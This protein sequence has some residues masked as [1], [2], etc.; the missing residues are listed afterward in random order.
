VLVAATLLVVAGIALQLNRR[1]LDAALDQRLVA[2]VDSFRNG[3]ARTVAGGP[4]ELAAVARDWLSGSAFPQS[5]AVAIA[6]ADGRVLTAAG[7]LDVARIEGWD[8]LLGATE[9]RWWDLQGPGGSIRALT[10]PLTLD[11]VHQGTIV[12][13]ASREADRATVSALLS[14]IAWA[15]GLGLVF[16]TLLGVLAVRRTLRPLRRM[17]EEAEQIE[18]SGDLSRRVR[19]DGPRDEVG[20]LA[21]AFDGMLARLED[22]FSSQRRFLSDASHELRTPLQVAR[23]QL[24]F[25]EET[26]RDAEGRRSV[27]LATEELERMRRIVE[28]LLLLAR[29]DEGM[30]LARQPVEVELVAREALL[31]GMQLERR[32][33]TVEIPEGLTALADQERLLQVLTNL[34][35]NAIHHGGERASIRIEGRGFDGRVAISVADTGPGIP[36]E[37]L[38]RVFERLYRGSDA[39]TGSPGGAGL[40]LAIA[41]SLTRTMGGE[42]AVDS[43]V[44]E[45]TTFTVT[46]PG[47]DGADTEPIPVA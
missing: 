32:D 46:L 45:G 25:L 38:P 27:A 26:V 14:G 43:V 42:I 12:V 15:S 17:S 33:H 41:A 5:E 10:T 16:A 13:A 24:E 3:P 31:R 35:T 6:T 1:N 37:E 23:G 9:A 7:G 28:D 2:T 30:P 29:L 21:E 18:E 11:G 47:I 36:P 4:G 34:V 20:R 40:G 44:G 22:A 19:S 8:G 39:R